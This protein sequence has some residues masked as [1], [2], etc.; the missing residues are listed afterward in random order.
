MA[1]LE[2]IKL[3]LLGGA[4]FL[5]QISK[6]IHAPLCPTGLLLESGDTCKEMRFFRILLPRQRFWPATPLP[7]QLISPD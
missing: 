5:A 6:N 7:E 2:R 4:S 1:G 3:A